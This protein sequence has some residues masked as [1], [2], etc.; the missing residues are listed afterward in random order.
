MGPTHPRQATGSPTGGQF[1]P[2]ANSESE[3]ELVPSSTDGSDAPPVLRADEAPSELLGRLYEAAAA[4]QEVVPDATLVGESA[5]AFYAHHRD[6]YDHDHVITDLADHYDM[7][8]EAIESLDGWVTNRMVPNK[9]ILG[10]IGDIEAGVRQLIRKVPLEVARY[11]LPSGRI[12]QVPTSDET[13][14]IKAYLI[15]ARNQT[16]DYL[17][18][19]ALSEWMT[20]ERAASV[21]S[22]IDRFYADQHQD[23]VGVA[24]QLVRQ[25]ADP[26]PKDAKTT[27]HLDQYKRLDR[28]WHD[29]N[30]VRAVCS[31]VSRLII[32]HEGS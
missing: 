29:W 11:Q 31:T 30:E 10:E 8:L 27:K 4:L 1:A 16:R 21:L 15:V 13:L 32:D 9:L 2:K 7:V 18:V 5:A 20:L 12:L 6:S 17:D 3:P 19:A 26:R 23:G 22:G 28:R 25:L 14:R 24:S